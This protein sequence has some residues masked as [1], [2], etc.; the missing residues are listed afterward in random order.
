MKIGKR[1]LCMLL[2]VIM[3]CSMGLAVNSM[4]AEAAAKKVS[5]AKYVRCGVGVENYTS[6]SVS[7]PGKDDN[8]K[9]IKVYEGKKT[10][11]N[12]V[13]KQTYRGGG[14]YSSLATL[15]MYAK[16]KGTY[17]IKFDVYKSKTSK[18][19]SH[20][21]TVYAKRN[22]GGVLKT[23]TIDNKKIYD[24][25]NHDPNP[26]TMAGGYYTTAKS[27]KVKFTLNEGY[28]ITKI[29]IYAS[30]NKKF[31]NGSKVTFERA[32]NTSDSTSWSKPMFGTNRFVIHY[33]DKKNGTTGMT[34]FWILRK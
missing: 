27:G 32:K 23:V 24:A 16:K 19:S 7:M 18:R 20:T 30:K 25:D 3:T 8:I 5:V 15:T 11:K 28:K 29:E 17:K 26:N 2:A 10:T 13:V 12:L 14:A 33:T 21:I 1:I 6:T 34:A 4:E 31:K 9:N 22:G